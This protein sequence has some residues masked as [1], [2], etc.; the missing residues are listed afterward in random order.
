MPLLIDEVIAEV[1]ESPSSA[2][3]TADVVSE[4]ESVQASLLE[5]LEVLRERQQR[6]EVD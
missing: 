5:Q 3:E 2:A 1:R 4:N 6:Q